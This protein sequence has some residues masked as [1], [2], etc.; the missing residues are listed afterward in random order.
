MNWGSPDAPAWKN[1]R[2]LLLLRLFSRICRLFFA[3]E[4]TASAADWLE[5]S[6][7]YDRK[8]DAVWDVSI[9]VTLARSVTRK[10]K[11]HWIAE[12]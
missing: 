7:T 10:E 2:K 11:V 5:N 3:D 1:N 8:V 4:I 6:I 12:A 9:I